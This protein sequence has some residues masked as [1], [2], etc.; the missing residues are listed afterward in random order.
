[1]ANIALLCLPAAPSFLRELT[2]EE[3]S[4]L[5]D[6]EINDIIDPL[7]ESRGAEF[8]ELRKVA[9]DFRRRVRLALHP[10]R[11]PDIVPMGE[12]LRRPLARAVVTAERL[13]I[14]RLGHQAPW[15]LLRLISADLSAGLPVASLPAATH[16]AD[17]LRSFVAANL[18]LNQDLTWS[19]LAANADPVPIT[20]VEETFDV[21]HTRGLSYTF[22][23][24]KT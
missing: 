18:D 10:G 7:P 5:T 13:Q 16:A 12:D 24:R 21:A 8:G 22:R 19:L 1:M 17:L 14:C 6:G 3:M 4:N 15:D 20:P 11:A 9:L 2:F 23:R